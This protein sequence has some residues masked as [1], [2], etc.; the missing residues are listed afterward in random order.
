MDRC[1][2]ESREGSRAPEE[3]RLVSWQC[4]LDLVNLTSP[5]PLAQNV[6]FQGA[7]QTAA[8]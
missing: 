3:K 7:T 1:Q 5:G 4:Q 8:A 6:V 2:P